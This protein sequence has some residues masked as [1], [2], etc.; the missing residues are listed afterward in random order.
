MVVNEVLAQ[1]EGRDTVTLP[2]LARAI[3]MPRPTREFATR[4]GAIRPI[5]GGGRGKPYLISMDEVRYVLACA[6]LC[7][8]TGIAI[9]A[10]LK[11]CRETGL[12]IGPAGITIPLS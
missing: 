7:A 8:I 10:A 5:G 1:W 2:E 6:A 3:E 12:T 9:T 4:T 11:A